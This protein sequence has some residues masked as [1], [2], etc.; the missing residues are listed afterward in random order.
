MT[1]TSSK[2]SS[3]P[4]VVSLN[5]EGGSISKV[6]LL[7]TQILYN[8]VVGFSREG[9]SVMYQIVVSNYYFTRFVAVYSHV[10]YCINAP[11]TN[12]TLSCPPNHTIR[13]SSATYYIMSSPQC[14][15]SI[16]QPVYGCVVS[17]MST[18]L[19]GCYGKTEC[20]LV[21]EK[22][23]DVGTCQEKDKGGGQHMLEVAFSCSQGNTCTVFEDIMDMIVGTLW[24]IINVTLKGKSFKSCSLEKTHFDQTY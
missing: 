22:K 13:V 17:D 23:T 5:W 14:T 3:K 15:P 16:A 8:C 2:L 9:D 18:N 1:A 10:Q 21:V 19:N 11:S 24:N 4:S 6:T 20:S 7:M 12:V